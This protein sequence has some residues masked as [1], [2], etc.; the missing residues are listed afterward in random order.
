[1][2]FKHLEDSVGET[3]VDD[4]VNLFR[5]LHDPT[6]TVLGYTLDLGAYLKSVDLDDS[7]ALFGGYAV[8]SHLMKEQG[9]NFAAV[10]RGSNDIDMAGSFEVI[11]A[12]KAGYKVH[13]CFESP[14]LKD[15]I[16]IKLTNNGD[17]ECRIDFY[18]GDFK[19]RFRDI[20]FNEHFGISLAVI[21]P[22]SII[23]GKL[24]TPTEELQH[25]GDVMGMLYT[26]ERRGYDPKYVSDYFSKLKKVRLLRERIKIGKNRFMRD[27]LGLFPSD[28]YFDE[29]E[30]RLHKVRPAI[31]KNIN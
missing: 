29:L 8:L 30:S 19:T 12:I 9:E 18:T 11:R 27:R 21:D 14:N 2:S 25:A 28:P 7:Y 23:Q 1:M 15:K 3:R 16:T 20:E 22:I 5:S 10:W 17:Q 26:L 24:E 4:Y 31:R 13:S 6:K